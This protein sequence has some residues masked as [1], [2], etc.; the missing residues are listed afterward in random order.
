MSSRQRLYARE[1]DAGDP[2]L[3]AAR[4]HV[5]AKQAEY[6]EH[7]SRVKNVEARLAAAKDAQ[8]RLAENL[9]TRN[10]HAFHASVALAGAMLKALLGEERA[11]SMRVAAGAAP[12]AWLAK[13][14]ALQQD[15]LL[16]LFEVALVFDQLVR[17]AA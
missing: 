15:R 2:E 3:E 11:P 5:N 17:A 16:S 9:E 1:G 6:V 13:A 12:P 7:L 4:N 14:E 8:K 10:A